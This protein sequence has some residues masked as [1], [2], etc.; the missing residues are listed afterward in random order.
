MSQFLKD[1]TSN[2]IHV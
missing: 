2:L 1:G